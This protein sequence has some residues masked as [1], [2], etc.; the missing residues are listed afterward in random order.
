M[1]ERKNNPQNN[2][3]QFKPTKNNQKVQ[4][5]MNKQSKAIKNNQNLLILQNLVFRD[6]CRLPFYEEQGN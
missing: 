2:Q 6:S 3:K 1:T 4:K 5:A